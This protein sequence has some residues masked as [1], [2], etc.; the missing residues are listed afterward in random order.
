MKRSRSIRLVLVGTAA[1]TLTA[2]GDDELVDGQYFADEQ[3]CS[4]AVDGDT[5][6]QAVADARG[7]HLLTAPRYSTR[8]QCEQDYGAANC[9]QVAEARQAPPAGDGQKPPQSGQGSNGTTPATRSYFHFIPLMHGFWYDR[10]APAGAQA[11]P[12]YRDAQNRAYSGR[13]YVG[14]F[15]GS[16]FTADTVRGGFGRTAT[17]RAGGGS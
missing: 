5:C 12:V 6:R 4:A 10:S 16:S 13:S 15:S 7:R 3:Q 8:E 11:A 1:F 14:N 2:C 17:A 9:E